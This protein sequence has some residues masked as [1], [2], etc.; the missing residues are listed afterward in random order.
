M[1]IKISLEEERDIYINLYND[2]LKALSGVTYYYSDVLEF[3][4]ED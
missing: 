3:T 1:N 4:N 2:I